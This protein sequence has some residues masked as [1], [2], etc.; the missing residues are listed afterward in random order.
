M[1]RPALAYLGLGSN[2][3]DRRRHL[4]QAIEQLGALPGTRVVGR[5]EIRDTQPVGPIEQGCFLNA[6]VAIE[7][8]LS[9]RGLLDALHEIE[10]ACGRDRGRETRWGPRTL[11]LDIL[12]YADVV[13]HEPGLTVPHPRLHERLFVLEPLAEIAPELVVPETHRTARELLEALRATHQGAAS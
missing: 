4:A 13:M 12:L 5:S 7:T 10:R 3:G 2:V 11:D 8:G 9:P 6:V 1:P